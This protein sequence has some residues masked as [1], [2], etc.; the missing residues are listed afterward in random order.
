M[1]K[2]GNKEFRNLQE[3]VGKNKKDIASILHENRVLNQFGIKVVG[4][5]ESIDD[6]PTVLEYKIDN[7]EW[8]YGDAYAIGEE[9][10]Y[11]LYVLTRANNTHEDDYW[12][13]IGKFP[14]PGPEGP[15]GPEGPKGPQ[16]QTGNTGT[17]GAAP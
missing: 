17:S 9:E 3:Q 14:A 4:Q 16:G 7:P 13:D 2:F 15:E 5:E 6:M 12:F 10:P 8:E 11:T 1:L